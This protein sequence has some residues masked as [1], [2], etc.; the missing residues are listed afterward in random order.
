MI[1][2]NRQGIAKGSI[3]VTAALAAGLIGLLPLTALAAQGARSQLGEAALV[4]NYA[5]LDI[6][7]PQGAERLYARIEQA[8]TQLC[9]QVP[10]EEL[11]RHQFAL[12]C[13][14]DVV[15]HTVTS[16]NSPQLAAVYASRTHRA[17]HSPV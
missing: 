9:P 7:T 5:D 4:V 14:N 12:R 1:S 2:E 15:A 16:I 17:T 3:A 11:Q 8:A 6:N 10:F 13:R